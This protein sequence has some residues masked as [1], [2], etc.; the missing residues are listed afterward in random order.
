MRESGNLSLTKE[1]IGEELLW[2][3]LEDVE[4][5]LYDGDLST[6]ADLLEHNKQHFLKGRPLIFAYYLLNNG[7]VHIRRRR[8]AEAVEEF[9][10]AGKIIDERPAGNTEWDRLRQYKGWGE[11]RIARVRGNYSDAED[12]LEHALNQRKA[13]DEITARV[14][15]DLAIIQVEKG[16]VKGGLDTY[17][18]G[19]F[20]LERTDDKKELARAYNNISDAYLKNQEWKKTL[21]FAD[22]CIALT[23]ELGNSRIQGFG[24][25]NAAEA[26]V[27]IGDTKNARVYLE[28]CRNAF[29]NSQESYDIGCLKFIEGLVE[30]ADGNFDRAEDAF[31]RSLEQL[32]YS[33]HRFQIGRI[34]H[35]YGKMYIKKGEKEKALEKLKEAQTILDEYYCI[36]ESKAVEKS[37]KSIE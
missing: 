10:E 28:I 3:I 20:L 32:E 12:I 23:R 35:E 2:A 4:S 27:H 24:S 26:L 7:W 11:S 36:D 17:L 9:E 16:N 25:M 29:E 8:M 22:K 6:A 1:D 31:D 13:K 19:I 37:L 5:R 34:F 14:L 21:E 30:T 33:D 18:K 15:I